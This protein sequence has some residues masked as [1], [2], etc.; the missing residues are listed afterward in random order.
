MDF[1]QL[2]DGSYSTVAPDVHE[3]LLRDVRDIQGFGDRA[4]SEFST[5]DREGRA[6]WF[7]CYY[8]EMITEELHQKMLDNIMDDD[9]IKRYV[10][11][12][13]VD[14]SSSDRVRTLVHALLWNQ[15]LQDY[16]WKLA[17]EL[18]A[19]D[20]ETTESEENPERGTSWTSFATSGTACPTTTFWTIS[21]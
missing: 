17:A 12:Y 21:S 9:F 6:E 15:E 16:Y 4:W 18:P 13:K 19:V 7:R 1:R 20:E 5:L 2:E 11:I 8:Q 3:A 10:A 14:C